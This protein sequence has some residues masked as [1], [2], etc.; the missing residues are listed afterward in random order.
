[1]KGLKL[2]AGLGAFSPDG[3]T[4]ATAYTE[5]ISL[6]D[7][8]GAAPKETNTVVGGNG[9]IQSLTFSPDGRT[10]YSYADNVA[11]LWTVTGGKLSEQNQIDCSQGR[12]GGNARTLQGGQFLAYWHRELWMACQPASWSAARRARHLR[13]IV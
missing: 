3:E 2:T 6:W 12:V 9:Y 7:L 11:R 5:K 10:L 4:L 13:R 1:M 8:H